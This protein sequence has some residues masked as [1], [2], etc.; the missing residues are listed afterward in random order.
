MTNVPCNGCT[1]CCKQDR[2]VLG[3]LD[4][5][6]AYAWHEEEGYAVLDRKAGGECIY[7]AADGCSIH[8]RAPQ[9]CQRFDCR[10]LL[11]NTPQEMQR[12]REQENP[13][14]RLIYAAARGLN[15][16]MDATQ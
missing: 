13:Q 3:P 7:L 8:G 14:M 11:T 5:P 9:I 10:E 15:K 6:K 12:K 1:A 2:V 16:R 4:D